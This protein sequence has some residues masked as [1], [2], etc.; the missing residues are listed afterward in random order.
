MDQAD[1]WDLAGFGLF[2]IISWTFYKLIK[3]AL[4][5]SA[6]TEYI[7]IYIYR[8]YEDIFIINLSVQALVCISRFFWWIYMLV[9]S[10]STNIFHI[11]P[12]LF[13]ME[14]Y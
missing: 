3:R 5:F 10:Y 8:Y 1:Y 2:S 13:N 11:D 7:Y 6:G 4:E 9:I 14:N 12:W